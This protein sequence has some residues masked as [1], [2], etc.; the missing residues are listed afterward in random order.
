MNSV[1]AA[2][3]TFSKDVAPIFYKKCVAC[4][5]TGDIAPM[6][7]LTYSVARPWAMAI[8]ERVLTKRMPPWHADP[9]YGKFEN[10]PSLSQGEMDTIRAWVDQGA[11][12]GDPKDLPPAPT[13]TEGWRIGKPDAVFTMPAAYT[14]TA[15][16]TDDYQTFAGMPTNF[17]EDTWVTAVEL[18]PGNRKVV[19]HAHV[20]VV[21]PKPPS[22]AHSSSPSLFD[23]FTFKEGS[24]RHIRPGVP[25]VDD[26]CREIG[27]G[28]LP[29]QKFHEEAEELT[30]FVPGRAPE[31]YPPGYARLIPAGS[32]IT[33]QIHYAKGTGN[34]EK[35]Q[36]SVGFIF[37][38]EPPRR[39]LRRLDMD[40]YLF[41]IPAGAANHE[42]TFCYDFKDNARLLAFTPHMHFRGKDMKWELMRPDATKETLLSI[43]RYDFNWQ[44]EYKLKVPVPA[45]KGSRL[46]VTAHF[47]NSA[48]N[49]ANPDPAKTM[50]WGEPT[51]EEMAASWV[52]YD[53]PEEGPPAFRS[54][55]QGRPK[56]EMGQSTSVDH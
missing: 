42:V 53:L 18:R 8:R 31:V 52:L 46:I 3:V 24:V 50:R 55:S 34:E 14:V 56:V 13:F 22:S 15:D 45:P 9:R 54:V 7:L 40:A 48:N 41:Q 33:F 23:R 4:H 16:A 25:V 19:H 39:V 6:P 47:D 21:P 51:S 36:S 17:K 37:A 12:E 5:H 2:N 20:Y 26:A 44:I 29:D 38:K 28:G 1:S 49:P 43:P 11:K 32:T 10:D 35:D 27:E 30:T